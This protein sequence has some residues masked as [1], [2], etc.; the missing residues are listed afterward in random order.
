[1][2][3]LVDMKKY[4]LISLITSIALLHVSAQTMVNV[5]AIQTE[6]V[7]ITRALSLGSQ[8]TKKNNDVLALQKYLVQ[9]KFLSVVP[10]GYFGKISKKAVQDFQKANSIEPLGSVG[11]ATRAKIKE[12]SCSNQPI[13]EQ[14]VCRNIG[15]RSEGWYN[16][17][18]GALISYAMCSSTTSPH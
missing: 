6:C 3:V 9:T 8:D 4:I 7:V 15:T 12:L 2:V 18:S 1:V 16:S 13:A 17:V 10:T 14:K 5:P 11:P